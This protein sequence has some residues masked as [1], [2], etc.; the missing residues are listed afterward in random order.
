MSQNPLPEMSNTDSCT[1]VLYKLF[2]QSFWHLLFFLKFPIALHT[3]GRK[4]HLQFFACLSFS[5]LSALISVNS[6][7]LEAMAECLLSLTSCAIYLAVVII[8]LVFGNKYQPTCFKYPG[9]FM[10]VLRGKESFLS[11]N[12][13]VIVF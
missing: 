8:L 1:S 9:T 4:S 2:S 7:L 12:N 5:V 3:V 13:W 11:W 6:H 10:Q